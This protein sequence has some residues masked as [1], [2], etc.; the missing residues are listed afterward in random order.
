MSYTITDD[1]KVMII[2]LLC[3]GMGIRAIARVLDLHRDTVMR[4]GL[5]IGEACW[6]LHDLRMSNVNPARIELDEMW[7]FVGA[8]QARVKRKDA[9]DKGDQYSFIAIDA[10]HKAIISFAVGKRSKSNTILFTL[11][12]VSRLTRGC[13]PQITTDGFSSYKDAVEIAFGPNADYATQIKQYK[14]ACAIDAD[15]RY[16]PA[17]VKSTTETVISGAPDPEFISTAYVE[18]TNLTVRGTNARFHRLTLCHSK[19]LRN[20]MASFALFVCYF[21]FC[22]KHETLGTTPA[23]A[24]GVE[25]K[26]WT[27]EDLISECQTYIFRDNQPKAPGTP[28]YVDALDFRMRWRRA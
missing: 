5:A 27:V 15:I 28:G 26:A 11:D 1:K 16:S 8:K 17:T 2:K 3:E 13:K 20:H 25:K 14:A 10:V 12:I 22:W 21:N 24:M 9:T 18:R 19:E 7:S 23:Q 6:H 4:Y